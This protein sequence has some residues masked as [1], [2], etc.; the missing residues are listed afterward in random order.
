MYRE[1]Y[2]T[3]PQAK[4][5]HYPGKTGPGRVKFP[6]FL[7]GGSPYQQQVILDLSLMN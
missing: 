3:P 1:I 7:E 6:Y 2:V 4:E 5:Y